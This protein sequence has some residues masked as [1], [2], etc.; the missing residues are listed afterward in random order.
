[1]EKADSLKEQILSTDKEIIEYERM[2]Y[3]EFYMKYPHKWVANNYLLI[4]GDRLV[5]NVPYSYQ[6]IFCVREGE[7]IISSCAINC[8]TENK[9]QLEEK[10]FVLNRDLNT[11]GFCEILTFFIIRD[12]KAQHKTVFNSIFNMVSADMRRRSI[13]LMFATC[14]QNT[15]NFYLKKGFRTFQE[16]QVENNK[17]FLIFLDI[18]EA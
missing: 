4:D 15:L 5:P 18:N 13:F 17:M 8:N 14:Y 9:S 11:K 3:K 10:G 12:K 6:K 2:L 16:R 7:R 1:M